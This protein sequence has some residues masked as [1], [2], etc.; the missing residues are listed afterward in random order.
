M[1]QIRHFFVAALAAFVLPLTALSHCPPPD[2]IY[3]FEW[4]PVVMDFKRANTDLS[5]GIY[6]MD[7]EVAAR[8]ML[9]VPPSVKTEYARVPANVRFELSHLRDRQTLSAIQYIHDFKNK[10]LQEPLA[11]Q[12]SSIRNQI[13]P[14]DQLVITQV[15]TDG[16][17][18][19]KK[20]IVNI[21]GTRPAAASA[22]EAFSCYLGWESLRWQ[23]VPQSG[24]DTISWYKAIG[25]LADDLP[26]K[27]ETLQLYYLNQPI[28]V[29]AATLGWVSDREEKILSITDWKKESRAVFETLANQWL[30]KGEMVSLY[31]RMQGADGRYFAGAIS[32][33]GE[34]ILILPS[35]DSLENLYRPLTFS[36]NRLLMRDPAYSFKIGNYVSPLPYP[37]Y[38][39]LF[40]PIV[41]IAYSDAQAMMEFP[42]ELWQGKDTVPVSKYDF[43]RTRALG[44]PKVFG[45]NNDN[46]AVKETALIPKLV[47]SLKT[48]DAITFK[49]FRIPSGIPD[50]FATF[51]IVSK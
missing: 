39:H 44:N 37:P 24:A 31:L 41:E 20:I 47:E 36:Q 7:A 23:M 17:T 25:L 15:Q 13:L 34:G 14:G 42:I 21:R 9:S 6:T 3:Y 38:T 12:V 35:G 49:R 46:T 1:M 45:I 22:G 4:G 40:D 29:T 18:F 19:D 10:T 33:E 2:S 30:K 50:Y 8:E 27:S 5:T 43:L 16:L 48:G 32:I 26:K 28:E 51:K 11:G